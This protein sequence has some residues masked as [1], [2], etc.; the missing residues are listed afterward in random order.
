MER[1]DICLSL[2]RKIIAHKLRRRDGVAS[3]T[4]TW[5]GEHA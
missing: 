2:A 5:K 4:E 1:D 3:G